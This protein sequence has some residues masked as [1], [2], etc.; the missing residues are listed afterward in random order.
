LPTHIALLRGINMGGRNLLPMEHLARL[1]EEAGCAGVRT[2]I[3]SGNVLFGASRS[4]AGGLPARISKSIAWIR[5]SIDNGS[6]RRYKRIGLDGPYSAA[7]PVEGGVAS[8]T[9]Q[10]EA[11]KV[12]YSSLTDAELLKIAANKRSF[13]NVAQEAL[14]NEL[15]GRNLAPSEPPR[16]ADNQAPESHPNPVARMART[17]RGWFVRER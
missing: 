12:Y 4:Q 15:R 10:Q 7:N 9:A 8:V 3:Q 17:V 13:L 2:Y 16:P 6:Q 1:F 5:R 14:A 11:F